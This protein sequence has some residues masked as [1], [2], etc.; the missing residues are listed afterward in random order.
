[1]TRARAFLEHM[2]QYDPD[3]EL[4]V[5]QEHNALGA[6]VQ[7]NDLQVVN[8]EPPAGPRALHRMLWQNLRLPALARHISAD[9]YL[10]FSHY[11]PWTLP[12]SIDSVIGVANL[13]PFSA[14]ALRAEPTWRGRVRLKLLRKTILSSVQRAKHVIALSQTCR[15]VLMGEGI[16][17]NKISV[18]SNGVDLPTPERHQERKGKGCLLADLRERHGI[19]GDFLL[20]V[21]HFY[22]YKNFH[23][24]IEAFGLLPAGLRERHQLVLVGAP[25][26]RDYYAS[27][28]AAVQGSPSRANIV[29]IPGL[30]APDLAALYR[31]TSLFVFPT[32]VENSPNIL[33]E[34]MA[35]GAPVLAGAHQPMPEF[36]ADAAGYFDA[37][38]ARSM[39]GT[40]A[41]TLADPQR[42][43]ELRAA[44]P[45]RAGR[46]S[47]NAFTRAVVALYRGEQKDDVAARSRL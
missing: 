10:S 33:L 40:M 16:A 29:V 28:I 14:E 25:H 41:T 3:S 47:W 2:R 1:M 26:N 38:S 37:L 30:H 35:H 32:L 19:R 36:A 20:Y 15:D 23:R 13:A 45:V 39:S 21:S 42:L 6:L 31:A 24:L 8:V 43:S 4:W 44:G 9:T 17:A 5:L 46:Y 7:R 12:T 11:L 27:V 22:P 34:A 18:I